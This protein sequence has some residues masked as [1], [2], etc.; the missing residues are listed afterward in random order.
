M[1]QKFYENP[2]V[3]SF[4]AERDFIEKVDAI[5]RQRNLTK[6]Q[7]INQA[8]ALF[9]EDAKSDSFNENDKNA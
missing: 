2:K 5:A 8:I 6:T 9:L 3:S 7:I 1:A 4:R